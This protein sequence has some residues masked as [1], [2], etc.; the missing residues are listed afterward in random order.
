MN[1]IITKAITFK[2]LIFFLTKIPFEI[3]YLEPISNIYLRVLVGILRKFTKAKFARVKMGKYKF[4]KKEKL[5]KISAKASTSLIKKY[6]HSI[7]INSKSSFLN[8]LSDISLKDIWFENINNLMVSNYAIIRRKGLK[9]NETKK[10][11]V[12]NQIINLSNGFF[13]KLE[14]IF[15][16]EFFRINIKLIKF[17]FL[18]LFNNK[19]KVKREINVENIFLSSENF[20][21]NNEELTL[22]NQQII[23]ENVS[24]SKNNIVIDIAKNKY[25]DGFNIKD[26]KKGSIF[27]FCLL[28][29]NLLPPIKDYWH[30]KYIFNIFNLLRTLKTVFKIWSVCR[31]FK[32]N[33]YFLDGNSNE[34]SCFLIVSQI[35]KVPAN[36]FQLSLLAHMNPLLHS[37]YANIIGFTKKHIELYEKE[38]EGFNLIKSQ[39]K[40]INYPYSSLFSQ[41]RIQ[42]L[43]DK[44]KKDFDL[45]VAIFDENYYHEDLKIHSSGVYFY[46][47]YI[48]ELMILL[49]IAY[50]NKRLALIFKSQ[51][52]YNSVLNIIKKNNELIKFY[53]SDQIFNIS[54]PN[55]HN[56]RNIVTPAEIAQ[57][58][59][60]SLSCTMGGTAGYEALSVGCRTLF[61]NSLLSSYEDIFPENIMIGNIQE[62]EKILDKIKYSRENLFK[63]KIGEID[64]SKKN[65]NLIF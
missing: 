22:R 7:Y 1:L 12:F 4:N 13:K 19:K 25:Y 21:R 29:D 8:I 48:K 41:K 2:K 45:S 14:V 11:L 46:D 56:E 33:N 16:I 38:S 26:I 43:S 35:F 5:L 36:I 37:P 10:V 61:V 52:M 18:P 3:E 31:L 62:L 17:I 30:K 49:K 58:V 23:S 6:R 27:E 32:A 65:F 51:F 50:K 59:D 34:G 47:D 42:N 55:S 63:T 44:L 57:S 15:A 64:T 54:F 60:L 24:G 20:A 53:N 9:K 40:K 39:S 28:F